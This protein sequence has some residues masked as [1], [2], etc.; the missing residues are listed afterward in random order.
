[1][2]VCA[3][4]PKVA[5]VKTA[6]PA[7]GE[8]GGTG[9]SPPESRLSIDIQL[10]TQVPIDMAEMVIAALAGHPGCENATI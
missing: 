7:V 9:I 4:G 2:I 6:G 1:M 3:S 10:G 5:M 8:G